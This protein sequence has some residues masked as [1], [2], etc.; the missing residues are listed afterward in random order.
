MHADMIHLVVNVCLNR[1]LLPELEPALQAAAANGWGALVATIRQIIS[2][3]RDSSLLSGLDD[4][5][6]VIAQTILRGLQDPKSLPNPATKP[7][8]T[9]AAP[10]LASMI[11]AAARGDIKALQLLA[12]MAE[13][14]IKAGGD[15]ARLGG[16][17]H[18]LING[19]RDIDKL[20]KGMTTQGMQLV[21][22]LLEEL[23]KLNPH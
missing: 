14:M 16:A 6:T 23:A 21:L 20:C 1:N 18:G 9:F 19:E 17:M 8:P 12:G 15:M 5:D 7:N 13:Q 4:E 11:N 3:R 22:L 10:G 2:G